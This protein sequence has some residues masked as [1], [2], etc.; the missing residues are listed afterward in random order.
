MVMSLLTITLPN[1][2]SGTCKD[3]S[4]GEASLPAAQIMLGVSINFSP[5]HT[6]SAVTLVT[7]VLSITSTPISSRYILALVAV[8]FG[9]YGKKLIQ[10]LNQVDLCL[11]GLDM[12]KVI[13]KGLVSQFCNGARHLYPCGSPSNHYKTQKLCCLSGIL[14]PFSPFI[15]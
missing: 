14:T 9:E 8:T 5:I 15:A 7:N 1:L 4:R 11:L 3:F 2:S 13:G 12:S 6:P 10:S